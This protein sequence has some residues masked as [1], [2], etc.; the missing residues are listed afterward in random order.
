MRGADFATFGCLEDEGDIEGFE[1]AVLVLAKAAVVASIT[2]GWIVLIHRNPTSGA[3]SEG[4]AGKEP[5]R[6]APAVPHAGGRRRSRGGRVRAQGT[7]AAAGAG[8]RR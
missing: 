2:A 4:A 1:K 8:A 5:E 7:A 6:R 3:G